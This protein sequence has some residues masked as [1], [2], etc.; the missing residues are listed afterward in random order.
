MNTRK[1]LALILVPLLGIIL[2]DWDVV[3][4]IKSDERNPDMNY[5]LPT[6]EQKLVSTNYDLLPR[7]V[8]SCNVRTDFGAKGD[9]KTDDTKAFQE[10][11]SYVN[12]I[13]GGSITVPSG[14]YVI[15]R[16]LVLPRSVYLVGEWYNPD[17]QPDKIGQGSIIYCI[18]DKNGAS[19]QVKP[20]I[21]IGA[22]AGVIGMTIYYPDQDAV[23]PVFYPATLGAYDTRNDPGTSGF[24]TMRYI[25]II[26]PYIGIDLGP[27]WSE[28]H[29]VNNIYMSPLN[30]GVAINMVTDIG[31]IQNLNIGAKYYQMFDPSAD[32]KAILTTM[33]TNTTGIILERSDWQH[34]SYL[35]INDVK[36][37]FI[38]KKF[39]ATNQPG[40]LNSANSAVFNVKMNNVETGIYFEYAEKQVTKLHGL[41]ITADGTSN[42]SCIKFGAAYKGCVTVLGGNLS[43][44]GGLCIKSEIGSKGAFSI[45]EIDFKQYKDAAIKLE[46]S[47][48]SIKGCKFEDQAENA[49]SLGEKVSSA[50][51]DENYY[52][53]P[54]ILNNCPNKPFI[55]SLAYKEDNSW[56]VEIDM[57]KIPVTPKAVMVTIKDPKYGLEATVNSDGEIDRTKDA[58]PAFQ[59]ALDDMGKNGGGIVFVPGGR[60]YLAG[61]LNIPTGVELRGISNGNHHTNA[62][63]TV[64][65]TSNGKNNINADPFISLEKGAGINGFLIWYPDQNPT[66]VSEYPYT[67]CGLGNDIWIVNITIGNGYNG[68]DLASHDCGGHFI[69]DIGGLCFKNIVS[70]DKSSKRGSISIGQFNVH[71]ISRTRNLKLH[72]GADDF[73]RDLNEIL[74]K[75]QNENLNCIMLGSTTNELIFDF[76]V[77]RSRTGIKMKKGIEGGCFDGKIIYCGFDACRINSIVTEIDVEK[78]ICVYLWE[79]DGWG[80]GSINNT[81]KGTLKFYSP[82]FSSWNTPPTS[83]FNVI[84]GNVILKSC[85]FRTSAPTGTL[86]TKGNANLT[87]ENSLFDHV[88]K[89]TPDNRDFFEQSP[90][91]IIDIIKNDGK[92]NVQYNIGISHFGSEML[93]NGKNVVAKYD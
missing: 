83:G 2:I 33:K 86:T 38:N 63:G 28:C 5:S 84:N 69:Y 12:S 54:G 73:S 90:Q 77:Y 50:T 1:I 20:F 40:P 18:A 26:N 45:S 43:N 6:I 35:V 60:Y 46:G 67:V 75:Q 22:A 24:A 23:S 72:N 49:I 44:P 79:C 88:G 59:K 76:F 91:E 8:S 34:F 3:S 78:D 32:K 56:K 48:A 10:A 82:N 52:A 37:G 51:I 11:I 61:T 65:F 87:I 81:G 21:Q 71:S 30:V 42:S 27:M 31:R 9:G 17:S 14:R 19:E 15:K 39:P 68:F 80:Y 16:A 92:L 47:T 70:I 64:L 58:T 29:L 85:Y 93:Q 25:T 7:Y 62:L 13:G 55:G 41:D 36:I 66:T 53:K 57:V 89:I 4:N 74:F